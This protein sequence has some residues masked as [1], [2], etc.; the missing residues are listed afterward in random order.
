MLSLPQLQMGSQW[1]VRLLF[2]GKDCEHKPYQTQ[3]AL[4]HEG[5][6]LERSVMPLSKVDVAPFRYLY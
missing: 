4:S 5:T 3:R 1:R 2:L 6:S